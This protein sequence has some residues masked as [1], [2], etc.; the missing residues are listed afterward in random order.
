MEKSPLEK[1]ISDKIG[2]SSTQNLRSQIE[3]YQLEKIR[4]NIG[5]VK[6][7]SIFYKEHLKHISHE[8]INSF[9]D[10]SK[11]PFTNAQNIKDDP[12]RFLCVSPK[13]IER[14][15]TL[16]TSGTSGIPKRIYFT[17]EDQELTIDF[18]QNGM[19]CL[20]KSGDRVLILL[21]GEAPGSV[22]DL[23]KKGLDRSHIES[24]IYGPVKDFHEVSRII[25]DKNITCIVGIPIQVLNL[26]REYKDI[27]DK[28]IRRILLSTDYVPLAVINE[29][30]SEDCMVFTHYGMTEMGLGGG[31]ECEALNGYHMREAD[32]YF[33]VIDPETGEAAEDGEYGEIVFTTLTRK[34]M[35]LIR[36]RTGD[37]GRF[38]REPCRCGTALR[39][40]ERISGRIEN[41]IIL[42]KNKFLSMRE[43]DE[44]ILK[45]KEI[46]NY[47]AEIINNNEKHCDNI[48]IKL[49]C[50]K[51]MPEDTISQITESLKDMTVISEGLKESR[52]ELIVE[53]CRDIINTG[54]G[55]LKRKIKDNRKRC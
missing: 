14:I 46:N 3:K 30:S 47:E 35:P 21:P 13:Y 23:L 17:E 25:K 16:N 52:I 39:T 34:G 54:N 12:L 18:F 7:N 6:K 27:F 1:W 42:W 44:V 51:N 29:L 53:T 28:Y 49:Q 33:E 10:F 20:V 31:V 8:S 24:F 50:D 38:F 40:M 37:L 11:V 19:N 2:C 5:Y 41:N 45:W 9:A 36:Y 4:E 48:I 43:L 22:G 55:T 26:K 32:L 15:V